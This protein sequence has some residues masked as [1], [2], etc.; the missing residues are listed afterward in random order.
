MNLEGLLGVFAGIAVAMALFLA[1]YLAF[2]RKDDPIKNGLLGFLFVAVALRIGK[3]IIFYILYDMAAVGLAAGFLGLASIG[4]LLLV[5]ISESVNKYPKL[6]LNQLLHLVIPVLGA[7]GCFVFAE[8]PYVS[9]LYQSATAVLFMY[10]A[11][12]WKLHLVREHKQQRLES[13]NKNLLLSV[14]IILVALIYQ[15][16]TDEMSDYMVGSGIAAV[17]IYWFLIAALKS[18]IVFLKNEG[19]ELPHEILNK[20]RFAFEED[21]VFKTSG[22]TIT[23]LSK[24]LDLPAYQLTKAIKLLYNKSF[25]ESVNSFRIKEMK[26]KLLAEEGYNKI[27]TLAYE[28]GFNTPSAFYA[29]FKKHTGM[30]PKEYQQRQV[31]E[32]A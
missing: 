6:N 7:I 9:L 25:P 5:Y 1:S 2:I 10:L 29:A 27:E 14:S 18:P 12:S 23:N 19:A 15:H 21:E 22:I 20:V 16:V 8:T 26:T 24:H 4:P 11:A 13:W 3:S 30:S 31:L 28:V 32:S 17:G